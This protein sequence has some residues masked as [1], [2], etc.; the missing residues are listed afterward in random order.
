MFNNQIIKMTKSPPHLGEI[1][2]CH[3]LSVYDG[4][5]CTVVY[6]INNNENSPFVINVRIFG[7]DTPERKTKNELEKKAGLLLSKYVSDI[8]LGKNLL[9]EILDWDKYGGRIVGNIII[10]NDNLTNLL[11]S[12]KLAKSYDGKTKK[13]IWSTEELE[14]IINFFND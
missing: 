11:L 4:D 7:I 6:N 2:N 10:D 14:H 8:I 13:E 5:T 12:N 9:L 1:V 3:V